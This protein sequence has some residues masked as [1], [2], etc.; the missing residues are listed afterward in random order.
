MK[1]ILE[2]FKIKSDYFNLLKNNPDF[3]K[4][5]WAV[6]LSQ[7]GT[8]MH[9][10]GLPWLVYDIS[11]SAALMAVNF[12][13]SL[14]P[15]FIFGLLGGIVSDR[16]SRKFIL[17][18]GDILAF[19]V[20]SV[21]LLLYLLSMPIGV[22][23]LFILT[24]AL[25]TLSALS[26]PSFDAAVPKL[27]SNKE[28]VDANGLFNVS[29]SFISLGGPV[30]AGVIIGFFGPWSNILLNGLSFLFSA[31]LI[32]FIRRD[33][34]SDM[35]STKESVLENISQG[36]NYVRQHI[37]LTHGIVIIFG[38]FLATGS[39]GSLIQ[40]YL[41]EGLNLEGFMFGFSFTLF[42]FLPMLVMGIYAPTLAKKYNYESLIVVGSIAF[43]LSLVGLGATTIYPVVIGFGMLL[44]GSAV[45][46]I[47]SWNSMRQERVPNNLLGRVSGV[48]FTLQSTALPIGGAISSFLVNFISAQ[49]T[50]IIF[51]AICL[52]ISIYI[53]FTPFLNN[54]YLRLNKVNQE[55]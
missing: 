14:I 48:A 15:G 43:S 55:T 40:F 13:V 17:I 26:T 21:F 7:I 12:T 11:G 52:A 34:N 37:W 30:F 46:I 35:K 54:D 1:K 19:L 36:A 33:I 50:F 41:R 44:N 32:I 9:R 2:S 18:S 3:H 4:L 10:F 6:I 45:L 42:E 22:L 53:I 29:R 25:S 23:S 31:I 24:F 47:I 27:V 39:V 8:Q 16:Y 20:I 49:F 28:I 51:G 5:M 38:V